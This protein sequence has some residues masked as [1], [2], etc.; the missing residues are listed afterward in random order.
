MMVPSCD[1]GEVRDT[2]ASWEFYLAI[3]LVSLPDGSK[4]RG[5][6]MRR[7]SGSKWN[8]RRPTLEEEAEFMSLDAW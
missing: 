8:Y 1:V 7:K 4:T 2:K 3:L 6:L 5:L